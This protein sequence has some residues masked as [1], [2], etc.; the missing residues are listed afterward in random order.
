MRPVL[1]IL[2]GL[3]ALMVLTVAVF[4]ALD[5]HLAE[6]VPGHGHLALGRGAEGR[7]SHSYEVVHRHTGSQPLDQALVLSPSRVVSLIDSNGSQGSA[8]LA[9]AAS[10]LSPLQA[11]PPTDLLTLAAQV[12]SSDPLPPSLTTPNPPP[13]TAS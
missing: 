5:H 9:L 11:L 10:W 1:W 12:S 13:I 2:S 3:M 8:E 7:H 4:P 6:R